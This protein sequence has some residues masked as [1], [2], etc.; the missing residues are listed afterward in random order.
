MARDLEWHQKATA[1]QELGYPNLNAAYAESLSCNDV[2]RELAQALMPDFK[3]PSDLQVDDVIDLYSERS[4]TQA[5]RWT[6]RASPATTVGSQGIE[7]T[8]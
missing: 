3:D 5:C 8:P 2:E 7:G 4:G 1:G 6:R